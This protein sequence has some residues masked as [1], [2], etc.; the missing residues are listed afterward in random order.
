VPFYRELISLLSSEFADVD[1][2]FVLDCG[3]YPG[4]A[5]SAIA[6]GIRHLQVSIEGDLRLRVMDIA[7]QAGAA[8]EAGSEPALDPRDAAD[9]L[10]SCRNWLSGQKKPS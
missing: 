4:L 10:E 6:N 3:P 8:I 1:W 9:P 5:L 7:G 2:R